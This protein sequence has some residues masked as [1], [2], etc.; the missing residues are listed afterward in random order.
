M[1]KKATKKQKTDRELLESI[2][3]TID[4]DDPKL[5]KALE[6]KLVAQMRE[7]LERETAEEK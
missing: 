7:R 3:V 1:K 4:V 5:R 2:S 6:K